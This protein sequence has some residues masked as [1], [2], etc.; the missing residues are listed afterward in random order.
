MY[1]DIDKEEEAMKVYD[2]IFSLC[3][4]SD[5]VEQARKRVQGLTQELPQP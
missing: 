4:D 1:E 5:V 2:K 3:E